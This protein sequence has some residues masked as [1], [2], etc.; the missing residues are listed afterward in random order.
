MPVSPEPRSLTIEPVARKTFA[1]Y[2]DLLEVSGAASNFIN[3]GNV[4]RFRNLTRISVLGDSAQACVHVYRARA[5]HEPIILHHMERHP[6]GT[7]LFMPL[8][9]Q[10]FIVVVALG[11][12][13]DY[14]ALRAF[15]VDHGRG[16]N[17]A[18]NTWHYPLLSLVDNGD[19]LVV[20]H[21]D[22]RNNL[23]EYPLSIP[24]RLVWP[25]STG[26]SNEQQ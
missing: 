11:S 8:H 21:A 26:Y 1:P 2:G 23:E 14:K 18:R 13:P 6:R 7:Q 12:L 3:A 15:H 24:A 19:F 16:V 10:A 25:P 5:P 20:E 9:G 4:E 22:S 17:I